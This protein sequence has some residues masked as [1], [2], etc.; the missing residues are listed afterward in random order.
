MS[1]SKASGLE[2]NFYHL[3]SQGFIKVEYSQATPLENQNIYFLIAG[4]LSLS[5]ELDTFYRYW[6]RDYGHE[7]GI[8]FYKAWYYEYPI[9]TIGSDND[10]C[11]WDYES[12]LMSWAKSWQGSRAA[13]YFSK[14]DRLDFV[15]ILTFLC[16][17]DQGGQIGIDI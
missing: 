4:R 13:L 7:L 14:E 9:E 2:N 10:S 12:K 17:L 16:L 6:L 1:V 15:V 8:R 5:Q 3:V 11:L